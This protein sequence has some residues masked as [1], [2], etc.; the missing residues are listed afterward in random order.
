MTQKLATR[1]GPAPHPSREDTSRTLRP[2]GSKKGGGFGGTFPRAGTGGSP[3]AKRL[4]RLIL[5]AP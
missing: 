2:L 4:S 5:L 3:F 1:A